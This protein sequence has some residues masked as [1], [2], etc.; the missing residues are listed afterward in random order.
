MSP[1]ALKAGCYTLTALNT[2][3]SQY[4]FNYL[5]F[6]LRDEYG[7]GDRTNL[8]V[9]AMH[10]AIYVYAAWQG[11]KF[12]ERRGYI[13]SLRVGYAGLLL[14]MV[15]GAWMSTAAGALV[16]VAAYTVA[17]LLIWP[18]L[19]ALTMADEPPERVPHRV[20]IYNLTWSGSAAVAYFTGG[21]L[22]EWLG[23]GLIF[24]LPAALFLVQLLMVSW[25]ARRMPGLPRRADVPEP[26]T[27]PAG[28]PAALRDRPA[29]AAVFLRLAW[30][31][32]P[33]SYVAV[34]TLLAVMPG[35]ASRLGLSP[36]Q[37]GMF[38][39]IWFFARMLAFAL[40]W[41]WSGWHYRFR[42]LAG[43]YVLL[44]ASFVSILV[45]P[46]LVVLVLGQV[47]FGLA[48]GM[49]Y[50][51]SLFYSMDLSDT[52]AEHGGL[53]EAAIGLGICV[54]PAVGAASLQLLPGCPGAGVVAVTGLLV[55]GF[56]AMLAV[57]RQAPG[58]ADPV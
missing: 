51:S 30:M 1:R 26:I 38:C 21:P 49:A 9:A 54:G 55:C 43:G 50:Y 53:H 57:W 58:A 24:G 33:L 35:L 2:L 29:R 36:T 18:A 10:G 23:P 47:V 28:P 39:S 11:G 27:V 46:T 44:V 34:Y 48:T 16:V 52:K 5:F 37:V 17:L 56:G 3:A 13:T 6:Y 41:Q 45:A 14:T 8:W 40:L 32:N 15:A 31:A 19:E 4:Y 25:L 7:F 22:Y 20:G 42:F 12:A